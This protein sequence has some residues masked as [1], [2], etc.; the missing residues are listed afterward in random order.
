MIDVLRSEKKEHEAADRDMENGERDARKTRE[1]KAD[2]DESV[3]VHASILS[4]SLLSL[5]IYLP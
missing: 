3:H 1:Q 4:L 2:E 5:S